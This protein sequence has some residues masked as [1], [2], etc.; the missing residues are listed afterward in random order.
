[1][2][3][4]QAVMAHCDTNYT[5]YESIEISYS[6]ISGVAVLIFVPLVTIFGVMSNCAFIYVVYH[7]QT[8]RNTINIF[9][10]NL[11]VADSSLLIAAFLEYTINLVNAPGYDI[12]SSQSVAGCV[13]PGFLTYFCYYASLW[14]MILISIER[15]LAI[16][17]PITY[18]YM[19]GKGRAIRAVCATWFIAF[20][21]A[22]LTVPYT[23]TETI[24]LS[25]YSPD[26]DK[27]NEQYSM[28]TRD[29]KMC[30]LAVHATDL[31]QFVVAF[32]SN[33]VLYT[34]T[35]RGLLKS[36]ITGAK[37]LNR[38]QRKTRADHRISVAKMIIVNGI[39][40]FICITPFSVV[41]LDE[42]GLF[43]INEKDINTFAWIARFLFLL[44]AALNP[45]IYNAT[46]STYRSAFRETFGRKKNKVVRK[47]V[48][49]DIQ[50]DTGIRCSQL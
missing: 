29:C 20:V 9:L 41:N 12:T 10:V 13:I 33:L 28:C 3:Y 32:F 2:V 22:I 16:C 18:K 1:M 47:E 36:V 40:F 19:R 50:R 30:D 4:I 11:A 23:T 8:M 43:S 5:F 15:Y 38:K 25:S 35:V 26:D 34:L 27:I 42:I 17:H 45:I 24:C 39:V 14:T 6:V 46:N 31:L 48:N 37:A 21:F 49:E 7:V 44:N